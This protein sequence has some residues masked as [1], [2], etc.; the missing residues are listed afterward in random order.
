M[1]DKTIL[2]PHIIILGA[3]MNT[4]NLGVSA[5]LTSTVKCILHHY[6]NAKFSLLGHSRHQLF[7]QVRLIDGRVVR[8]DLVGIRCNKTLWRRNHLLRLLLTT[9]LLRLI[10]ISSWKAKLIDRNPYLK[11]LAEAKMIADITG[12]DSF[13]DIYGMK[14]LIYGCM[15]KL[16]VLAAKADLILLPQTY[17]PF[18]SFWA[19]YLARMI[20]KNAKKVYSRDQQSLETI[21]NLM[22]SRKMRS[23]PQF[24]PDV[25]FVLDG[26]A[27][28][29]TN[30]IPYSIPLC[31]GKNLVGINISGL[32][33]N[34]G[35]S[36]NNMFGLKCDYPKLIY[37]I[38]EYFL[39]R[40]DTF[41]LLVP[42]V[43]PPPQLA[44]ESDPDVCRHVYEKTAC[45]FPKKIFLLEGNYD[46]NEIKYIIGKCDFFIGSRMHSCIAAIS[47]N[48]P[49][50]PLAY[51]RKFMG[52]FDSVKES[53]CV[54]DL[55]LL[56]SEEIYQH[57]EK[58]FCQRTEIAQRLQIR[59]PEIKQQVLS[60]LFSKKYLH[61]KI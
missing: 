44:V 45:R 29:T 38:V 1:T 23:T 48:I 36:Q 59:I 4:G 50:V 10:P 52:V 6:P 25:A 60:M 5:L 22:G 18:N 7:E 11:T 15:S 54:A 51:S 12:G 32:L 9:L 43:F 2:K 24:C 61:N 56:N 40:D 19:R 30:I 49:T 46:P 33:Y 41:V 58:L 39:A 16:L 14:R 20:I 42:H 55:K 3:S 17:G 13:S 57:I 53:E 8:L 26:I 34:G 27:P 35:Y 31:E 28:K 37:S 21:K 47:H